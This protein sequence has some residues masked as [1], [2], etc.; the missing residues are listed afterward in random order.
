MSIGGL[1][2]AKQQFLQRLNPQNTTHDIE[3]QI[4]RHRVERTF[5]IRIASQ[6]ISPDMIAKLPDDFMYMLEYGEVSAGLAHVFVGYQIRFAEKLLDREPEEEILKELGRP[7]WEFVNEALASV[8]LGYR[9]VPS[10]NR[11][12]KEY[13]VMA[14]ALGSNAP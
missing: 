8:D 9:I 2:T 6:Q 14:E 12:M 1:H 5:G 3:A 10:E 7:P 13:R 11:L 4:L